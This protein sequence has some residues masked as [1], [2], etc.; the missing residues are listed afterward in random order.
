MTILKDGQKCA[1]YKYLIINCMGNHECNQIE[2]ITEM[3][4]NLATVY[5]EVMGNGK[6]GLAKTAIRLQDSVSTLVDTVEKFS[7]VISGF[8]KFQIE[9]EVEVRLSEKRKANNKWLLGTAIALSSLILGLLGYIIV[10]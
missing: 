10:K 2:K 4:T 3:S 7:T 9:T 5:K 8:N 6:E 1:K